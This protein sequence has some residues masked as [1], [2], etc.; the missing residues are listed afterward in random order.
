MA[1]VIR[2]RKMGHKKAPYFRL[3][4]TDK[5]SKRDGRFIEI[6]GTYNPL[7][8]GNIKETVNKERIE[9]WL[10][11]GAQ[12]SDTA[13]S[14]LKRNGIKKPNKLVKKVE[15]DSKEGDKKEASVVEKPKKK[16]KKAAKTK[17]APKKKEAKTKKKA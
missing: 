16:E 12:P 14:I 11:Q 13:W 7:V 8:A 10:S 15:E 4:V 5:R 2:L 17:E 9:Y 1:V 6:V 3:V